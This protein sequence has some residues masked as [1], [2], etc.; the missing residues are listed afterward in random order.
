MRLIVVSD[1][2]GR[3]EQFERVFQKQSRA[4][5]FLHLGDGEADVEIMR[6]RHP[7]SAFV[8]VRGN[9]DIWSAEPP[10]KLMELAGRRVFFTHG[11]TYSVKHGLDRF[12]EAA[13]SRN[14]DVALFGHT[15]LPLSEYRDG[16]YV[17]NPGSAGFPRSN[18]A[19]FAVI[20]LLESGVAAYLSD[21]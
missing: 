19:K 4:D 1:T 6:G 18:T 21:I 20:D 12:L 10:E 9:C 3:T 2:H 13:R 11:H 15:H 5:L 7:E 8:T 14:A 16:M 17:V